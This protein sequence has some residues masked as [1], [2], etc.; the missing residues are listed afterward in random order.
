MTMKKK[1]H[2]KIEEEFK[3]IFKTK[4]E[5]GNENFPYGGLRTIIKE[6][7]VN[8]QI[9]QLARLCEEIPISVTL[10]TTSIGIS[11]EFR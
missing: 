3:D 1:Y 8:H 9:I 10:K 7:L 5:K 2:K 11:I 4:I 6:P